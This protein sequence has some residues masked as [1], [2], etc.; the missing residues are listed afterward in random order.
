MWGGCV[1]NVWVY[2]DTRLYDYSWCLVFTTQ[3][4][5]TDHETLL[6][7]LL[8]QKS[9]TKVVNYTKEPRF[10]FIEGFGFDI[11][12]NNVLVVFF[13]KFTNFV[14]YLQKRFRKKEKKKLSLSIKGYI[15]TLFRV[16]H[17]NWVYNRSWRYTYPF[18]RDIVTNVQ[19]WK[20]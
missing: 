19:W 14:S 7:P 1:H 15:T 10:K 16:W 20:I 4:R 6:G 12:T 5:N 2:T 11:Y 8:Y 17:K 9:Q 18:V 3:L 13:N